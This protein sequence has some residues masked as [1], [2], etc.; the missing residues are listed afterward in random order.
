MV[1]IFFVAVITTVIAKENN[2]SS[3]TRL[4]FQMALLTK[5]KETNAS[6]T[7]DGMPYPPLDVRELT[8]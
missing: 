4:V 2:L 3:L 8:K 1:H 5:Q 7:M 6:D